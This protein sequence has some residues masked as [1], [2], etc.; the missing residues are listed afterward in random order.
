MRTLPGFYLIPALFPKSIFPSTDADLSLDNL[1]LSI[2][3]PT[4]THLLL[5]PFSGRP[6][7]SDIALVSSSKF[8]PLGMCAK[9]FLSGQ[10]VVVVDVDKE[11][12]HIAC[13]GQTK[14]EIVIPIIVAGKKLGVLDLDCEREGGFDGEDKVGLEMIVETLVKLTKW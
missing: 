14:S 12:G 2:S 7:C 8:R 5:G 3:S 10:T 6:A 4:P 9:A 1:S 13:D 11:E